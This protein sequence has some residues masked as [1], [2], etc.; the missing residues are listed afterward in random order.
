MNVRQKHAHSW[1][2][3][4]LGESDDP[5]RT[6]NWLTLDPTPGTERRNS[7]AR[8]G[9]FKANFRQITDLVRYVWVF[10]VVGYN[11]E[12][13]NRLLY[14]PIRQLIDEAQRGFTIIGASLKRAYVRLI[15]FLH[16]PNARSFVS[17]RGFGVALV[18]LSLLFGAFWLLIGLGKRLLRW[19]LGPVEEA[20][21]L[22]A[23]AA[24]YR[25]LAQLLAEYDLERTPAETQSEFARRATVFLT[26]RGSGTETVADVPRLVV[27]A[28]Y[29]VRFGDLALNPDELTAL[30]SRLNALEGS[31]RASRG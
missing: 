7:V 31:L 16:F 26:A 1:V 21:A 18:G 23:G 30:D 15:Q 9:G 5:D 14:G 17:P 2:E 19:Y 28:F 11:A 10:Y 3:A 4:Y 22:S 12:R 24:H 25:R 29:R 13:Q 6:P 20:G 8:V 27:E